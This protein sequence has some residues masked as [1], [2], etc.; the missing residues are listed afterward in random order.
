MLGFFWVDMIIS[1]LSVEEVLGCLFYKRCLLLKMLLE[2]CEWFG[3]EVEEFDEY[4]E[5]VLVLVW[6][7]CNVK[8]EVKDY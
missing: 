8:M 7:W 4:V 3:I 5:Y 2:F 6:F 1:W